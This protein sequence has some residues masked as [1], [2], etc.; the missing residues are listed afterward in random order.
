MGKNVNFFTYTLKE[1]IY[2]KADSL[3]KTISFLT[4]RIV[5]L[6]KRTLS[7]PPPPEGGRERI[8]WERMD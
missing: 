3:Y 5:W 2:R 8:H 6:K 1:V 4:A 7:P